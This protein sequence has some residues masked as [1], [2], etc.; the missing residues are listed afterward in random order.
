MATQFQSSTANRHWRWFTNHAATWLAVG[1]T[2]LVVAPLVAIFLDLVYK[3][4][5]SLNWDFFTKL[6]VPPGESGGGMANAIVGS[7]VVLSL[8]SLMGIPV[9]IAGGIYLSEFGRGTKLST[10]V[11]FTAD[12]LNGVPSIVMG[13]A[14]YG[15]IVAPT[16]TF[17]ALA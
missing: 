12:I 3:G 7:I 14:I 16:K 1:S 5:S 15:L 13:I 2:I 6:P 4:A 17:S 10:V 11:R 9:G 8:A